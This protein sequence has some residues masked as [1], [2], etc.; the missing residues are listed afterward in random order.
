MALSGFLSMT[1]EKKKTPPVGSAA[2]YARVAEWQTQ[3]R[4]M[5]WLGTACGFES[6]PGY[7]PLE[8]G[9]VSVSD[10]S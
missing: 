2:L 10:P 5:P 7:V 6:R 9:N 1:F 3:G 4:W 8:E